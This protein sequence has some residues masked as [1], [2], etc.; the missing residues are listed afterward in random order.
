[1]VIKPAPD[2]PFSAFA[3][4]ELADRAGVP[5]G[6]RAAALPDAGVKLP[7]GFL[8]NLGRPARESACECERTAAPSLSQSL[9][10][11]NDSFLLG[12]IFDA[13]SRAGVLATADGDH[14]ARIRRLFLV[15]LSRPATSIEV[16]KAVK[17]VAS[18]SDAKTAYSNLMWALINTK[19][20][21]YNH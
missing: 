18:E 20:F 19:E 7:D 16:E 10:T 21:Q 6:I 9:F 3:L 1:M 5:A 13:K 12:K 2:T 14:A 17:Y 15:A 4:C 8:G 11:L